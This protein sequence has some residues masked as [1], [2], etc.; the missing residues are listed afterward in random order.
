MEVQPDSPEISA[1]CGSGI[2]TQLDTE[3]REELAKMVPISRATRSESGL[4][5]E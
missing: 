5:T 2:E 1:W 4:L 3:E